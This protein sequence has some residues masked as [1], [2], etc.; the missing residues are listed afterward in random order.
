MYTHHETS[1]EAWHYKTCREYSGRQMARHVTPVWICCFTP[2]IDEFGSLLEI[3]FLE[4]NFGFLFG[5]PD[6]IFC[7][8]MEIN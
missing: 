7:R 4:Y 8:Y 3:L 5:T 1:A 6:L 2:M